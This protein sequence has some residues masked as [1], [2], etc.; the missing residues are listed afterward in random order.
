MCVC[1]GGGVTKFHVLSLKAVVQN[2]KFSC[3]VNQRAH[4]PEVTIKALGLMTLLVG[5]AAQ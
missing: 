3:T 2:V 5:M 4:L 1:W